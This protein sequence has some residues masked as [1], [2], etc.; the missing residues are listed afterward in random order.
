MKMMKRSG[1]NLPDD[2]GKLIFI[3]IDMNIHLKAL[4]VLLIAVIACFVAASI[5]DILLAAI[6]SRF[7]SNA[8]FIVTFGVAGI[9]AGFMGW[10]YQLEKNAKEDRVATWVLPVLM[11]IIASLFIFLLAPVEGGEYASAFISFGITLGLT[12]IFT[13]FQRKDT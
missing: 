6:Y 11:I 10:S 9:F 4:L 12:G 7:Y 5:F 3:P 13:W 2:R 8:L 1:Q